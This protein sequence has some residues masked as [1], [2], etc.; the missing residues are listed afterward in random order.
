[1]LTVA[2]V[3]GVLQ[4]VLMDTAEEA[5]RASG[6]VRRVRRFTGATFVQTLVLGWLAHPAATLDQ[7]CQT[8]ATRGVAITPQGLAARFTG[9]AATCLR[10]V[11]EAAVTEVVATDPAVLPLLD[12]F[13]AVV[14]QDSTLIALPDA[15]ADQWPG[16][17]GGSPAATGTQAAL[18]LQVGL[19]L[20][21][22]HLQGPTLHP[23]RQHDQATA[24]AVDA[25]GPDALVL[26]DLGYFCL[27][28]LAE[29]SAAGQFWVS[30]PKV[31]V[32]LQGADG[33]P[34][35]IAARV[36]QAAAD[37]APLVD[38]P[39]ALGVSH[40]LACRLVAVPVPPA[41]AATQRRKARAEARKHGRTVSADRLTL[42]D[43]VVVVTN[44]PLAQATAAEVLVLARVR[45]QIELVFKRWK[46]LGQVD[47]W[48]STQPWRILCEVYAKL[49]GVVVAHWATLLG[50]WTVPNR[51]LWKALG[52]VQT[53]APDLARVFDDRAQVAAVLTTI[54]D[55]QRIGCRLNS[56]RT[57]PNTCQLLGYDPAA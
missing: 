2:K 25:W 10:Q 52:V 33:A 55:V 57:H 53:H 8:A 20:R 29:Q 15:L 36:Q 45:W 16:C 39:V 24:L 47:A 46:S 18:K 17:G 23:G 4:R 22:G 7:L 5:A 42:A 21:G 19:D 30:R 13:A 50:G 44:V 31:N 48:R 1:M 12:R 54:A 28:R 49:V 6:C 38:E 9:A 3:A 35:T 32:G 14:V 40:R 56:R 51:S 11:L 34:T 26:R 37:G 41:V 43:W 27:D